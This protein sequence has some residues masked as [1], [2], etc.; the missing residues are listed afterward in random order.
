[1]HFGEKK[2]DIWS[3]LLEKVAVELIVKI[4]I[5]IYISSGRFLFTKITILVRTVLAQMVFVQDE[6]H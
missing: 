6:D 3:F 2:E 5:Y 4:L 1:M